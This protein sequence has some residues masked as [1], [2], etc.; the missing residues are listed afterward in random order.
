MF[1]APVDRQIFPRALKWRDVVVTGAKGRSHAQCT[2]GGI[3]MITSMLLAASMAANVPVCRAEQ[4]TY[5][6]RG[7]RDVTAGFA[8]QRFPVNFS[9][10]LFFWVEIEGRRRWFSFN[11]PNGYGGVYLTP[12]R[13]P[14][15]LT[16]ADQEA[17]AP[18]K[19]EEPPQVDF[20]MFDANYDVI[21][22]V[23]QAES[24]APAHLFARGL[25]PLLWYNPAAAANGDST[26]TAVSIPIAM[27]DL[28][29]CGA[30]S[31]TNGD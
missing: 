2:V 12:D 26:A 1:C 5:A 15:T 20:D 7:T 23:P 22:P 6:L 8:R 9:S 13:D 4:A 31:K 29:R 14:A 16:E 10:D 3:I 25:G 30:G 28:K 21:D 24:A 27:Y 17:G 11:A 18:D 19:A